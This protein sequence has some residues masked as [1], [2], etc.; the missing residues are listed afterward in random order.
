MIFSSPVHNLSQRR[1]SAPSKGSYIFLD[2]FPS[3][4]LLQLHHLSK[5]SLLPQMAPTA[6]NT[7]ACNFC[8]SSSNISAREVL[9][10]L[11]YFCPS[12]FASPPPPSQP[13]G[14]LLPQMALFL[15][16]CCSL[17]PVIPSPITWGILALLLP[18]DPS[19]QTH[20]F[21]EDFGTLS[22]FYFTATKPKTLSMK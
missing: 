18:L 2:L 22:V 16:L 11:I 9:L 8:F 6:S 10:L 17:I 7:F 14:V 12:P 5:R 3:P 13:W 21:H 1:S 20:L 19:S 15:L 4:L